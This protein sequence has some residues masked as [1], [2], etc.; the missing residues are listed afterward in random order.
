MVKIL[1]DQD[2]HLLPLNLVGVLWQ[3]VLSVQKYLSI[4]LS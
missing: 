1:F 3:M 2:M 4:Y